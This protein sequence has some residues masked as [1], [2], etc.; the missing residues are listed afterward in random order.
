MSSRFHLPPVYI[1]PRIMDR[2]KLQYCSLAYCHAA[3][4]AYGVWVDT[5][6]ANEIL[7]HAQII[8]PFLKSELQ[9]E[10][11]WFNEEV[12]DDEFMPSGK[13]IHSRL[14]IDQN[15]SSGSACIFLRGDDRCAL[16]VAAESA[17]LHAW[18]FKPAYCILHPLDLDDHGKITLPETEWL[19]QGVSRCMQRGEQPIPFLV[20]FAAEL[21]YLFGDSEYEKLLQQNGLGSLVP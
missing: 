9:V 4:C 19:L 1:D 16:Q 7:S 10:T 12:E 5:C 21:R 15:F 14:A 17:H 8:R 20:M 2:E 3:C 6:E 13:V 11:L 18:R